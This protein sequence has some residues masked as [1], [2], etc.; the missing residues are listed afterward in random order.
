MNIDKKRGCFLYNS[1]RDSEKKELGNV[2]FG[3]IFNCNL[4]VTGYI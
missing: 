3:I 4:F 1:K 2:K